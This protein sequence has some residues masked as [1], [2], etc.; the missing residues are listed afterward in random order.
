MRS[1]GD[2]YVKLWLG[3]RVANRIG[4]ANDSVQINGGYDVHGHYPTCTQKNVERYTLYSS[5]IDIVSKQVKV[6]LE[7]PRRPLASRI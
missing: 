4:Y 5:Y 2:G 1:E 3:S 7:R 6:T